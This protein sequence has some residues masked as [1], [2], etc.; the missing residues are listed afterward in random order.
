MRRESASTDPPILDV[1]LG[2]SA[3]LFNHRPNSAPQPGGAGMAIVEQ[4]RA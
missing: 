2:L 3:E 1:F 4:L